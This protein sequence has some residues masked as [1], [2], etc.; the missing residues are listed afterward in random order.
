MIGD[1]EGLLV[2]LPLMAMIVKMVMVVTA[3][4]MV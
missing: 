1:D 3:V 2:V 4:E